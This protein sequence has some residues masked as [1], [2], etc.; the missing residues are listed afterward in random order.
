MNNNCPN[1]TT[2][3]INT[4]NSVAITHFCN[5]V[6]ISRHDGEIVEQYK[7]SLIKQT[8]EWGVSKNADGSQTIKLKLDFQGSVNNAI[9]DE[10]RYN[11][12]GEELDPQDT[13]G[14]KEAARLYNEGRRAWLRGDFKTVAELFGVLV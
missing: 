13:W 11:S 3:K 6:E 7:K 2:A 10:P 9:I 4:E 14:I 1:H 5:G 8:K 12:C